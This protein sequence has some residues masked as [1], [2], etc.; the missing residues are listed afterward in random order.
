MVSREQNGQAVHKK[1]GVTQTA[2]EEV[3]DARCSAKDLMH[4]FCRQV[5]AYV[6]LVSKLRKVFT[7]LDADGSGK[8][9]KQEVALAAEKLGESGMRGFGFFGRRSFAKLEKAFDEMDS[10]CNGE[11]DFDEFRCWWV[12]KHPLDAPPDMQHQLATAKSAKSHSTRLQDAK[13]LVHQPAD[14]EAENDGEEDVSKS[15][16]RKLITKMRRTGTILPMMVRKARSTD[17]DDYVDPRDI[18]LL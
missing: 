9:E 17:K 8:L 1:E 13:L 10:D 16:S 12:W 14:I 18:T 7:D 3:V 6:L 15:R 4:F 11:V 2:H 5:V